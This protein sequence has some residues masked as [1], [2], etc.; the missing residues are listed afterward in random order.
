VDPLRQKQQKVESDRLS[1]ASEM[2]FNACAQA[3][4]AGHR[5]GWRNEKHAKQ[6]A[7]TLAT[8]AAPVIGALPVAAV[9]TAH[10]IKILQPIWQ[11]RTET[12]TRLRSRIESVLDWATVFRTGENPARWRNLQWRQ[13]LDQLC[14]ASTPATGETFPP[15]F[16]TF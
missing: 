13:L 4:I 6:W 3:C 7:S 9:D 2:T 12:A 1:A 14:H 5:A 16:S 8:Y 11:S 10:I 15:F